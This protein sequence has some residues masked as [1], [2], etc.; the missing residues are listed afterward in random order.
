MPRTTK[1]WLSQEQQDDLERFTRSRTLA[2][3]SLFTVFELFV[4]RRL[5]CHQAQYRFL[6]RPWSRNTRRGAHHPCL[7]GT[8]TDLRVIQALVEYMTEHKYGPR[9]TIAEGSGEWLPVE[10]SKSPVDG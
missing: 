6:P 5:G 1:V 2:A 8:V 4:T 9:I 10:R 3:R 7:A